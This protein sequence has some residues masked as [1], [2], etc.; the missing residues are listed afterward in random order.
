[1]VRG[2]RV[3]SLSRGGQRWSRKA[4][5]NGGGVSA[6]SDGTGFLANGGVDGGGS[7]VGGRDTGSTRLADGDCGCG[8]TALPMEAA[9]GGTRTPPAT[10]LSAWEAVAAAAV[11]AAV[12][13][14]EGWVALPL[15]GRHSGVGA[16]G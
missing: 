4:A 7:C 3:A 14:V 12:A 10:P 2:L 8:E 6:S 13:E 5:V 11:A 9:V 16:R 15:D 1:M